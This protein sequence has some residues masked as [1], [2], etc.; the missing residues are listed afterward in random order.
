MTASVMKGLRRHVKNKFKIETNLIQ[1]F[2]TQN[3]MFA[4]APARFDPIRKSCQPTN[5]R[6][7]VEVSTSDFYI[8]WILSKVQPTDANYLIDFKTY[9]QLVVASFILNSE[10]GGPIVYQT[11]AK[12]KSGFPWASPRGICLSVQRYQDETI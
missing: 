2:F 11:C 3:W 12:K 6:K 1:L 5:K 10:F 7:I 9:L 4:S 8:L